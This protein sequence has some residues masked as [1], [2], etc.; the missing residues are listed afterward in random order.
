MFTVG[1]VIVVVVVVA[2]AFQLTG[3]LVVAAM[4]TGASITGSTFLVVYEVV[5]MRRE[6]D[7]AEDLPTT[8]YPSPMH[9]LF[10]VSGQGM[11][12]APPGC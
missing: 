12:L 3:V 9:Q 1:G 6:G 8:M 10:F 5:G 11:T 2:V 4:F 7:E